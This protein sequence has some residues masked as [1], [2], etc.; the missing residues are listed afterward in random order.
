MDKVT[1]SDG[2]AIVLDRADESLAVIPDQIVARPYHARPRGGIFY[3]PESS[4]RWMLLYLD[5]Q[6]HRSNPTEGEMDVNRIVS[7]DTV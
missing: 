5:P 6:Y 2:A 3:P 1:S 7:I 4:F